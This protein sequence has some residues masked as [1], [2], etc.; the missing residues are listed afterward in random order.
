MC[1]EDDNMLQEIQTAYQTLFNCRNG[2]RM[3]GG[4]KNVEKLM[5]VLC[6]MPKEHKDYQEVRKSLSEELQKVGVKI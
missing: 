2:G 5:K 1:L 3:I 4:D 6:E